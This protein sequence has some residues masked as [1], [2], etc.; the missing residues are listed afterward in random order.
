MEGGEAGPSSHIIRRKDIT[1]EEYKDILRKAVHRVGPRIH[2]R[3]LGQG[4]V[5]GVSGQG[6]QGRWVSLEGEEREG[7]D[8][9]Q[10][11]SG[12]QV[13]DSPAWT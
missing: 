6:R 4:D 5:M 1:K 8:F 9:L 13:Q 3:E 7:M 2:A 12:G 10:Q 11:T